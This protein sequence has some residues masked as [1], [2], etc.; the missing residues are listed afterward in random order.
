M[1]QCNVCADRMC[2]W[3]QVWV[4]RSKGKRLGRVVRQQL[5]CRPRA[6]TQTLN[7]RR[8]ET[9][10]TKCQKK[11]TAEKATPLRHPPPSLRFNALGRNK[12]PRVYLARFLHGMRCDYDHPGFRRVICSLCVPTLLRSPLK[13][14]KVRRQIVGGW[15]TPSV[16]V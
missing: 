14:A 11:E 9:V 15:G 12:L 10:P 4:K 13:D 5:G 2:V 7:L 6:L 8:T 3:I 16:V 1:F